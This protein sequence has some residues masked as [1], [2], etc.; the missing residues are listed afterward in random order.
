MMLKEQKKKQK[1]K[2]QQTLIN[3]SRIK[4]HVITP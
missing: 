4:A 1:Q 3:I 2:K